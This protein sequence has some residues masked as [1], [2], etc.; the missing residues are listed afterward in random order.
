MVVGGEESESVSVSCEIS[1][2]GLGTSRRTG[3]GDGLAETKGSSSKAKES[4]AVLTGVSV[5][6]SPKNKNHI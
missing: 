4:F 2:L 1:L 6:D 5:G 3:C